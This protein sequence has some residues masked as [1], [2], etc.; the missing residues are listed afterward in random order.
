MLT[1]IKD[2]LIRLHRSEQGAEGLEKLLIVGAIVLPLLL[3]LVLFRNKIAE[4][5]TGKWNDV[6]GDA[7][8]APTAP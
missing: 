7:D 8:T 4:W 2:S 5:V 3:V 1:R 6:Q